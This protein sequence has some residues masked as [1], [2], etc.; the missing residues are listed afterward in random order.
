MPDDAPS[1]AV[2]RLRLRVTQ[3]AETALRQGHPWVFSDSVRET[4]RAGGPGEIA[5]VYD[6][7][8]RFLAAGLWDPESPIRFRALQV[9]KPVV[10]DDAWWHR[11]L[12]E[13]LQRRAGLFDENTDGYRCINGESDGWPGFVLDRFAGTFVIKIYTEAW[14]PHLPQVLS[15]LR[16]HLNPERLVLRTSRNI[17]GPAA[18]A[19]FADGTV[20]HGAAVEGPVVFREN[21]LRFEAEVVRGQKTGFFLD[22]RENR[23]RVGELAPGRSVLNAFSFSGGFSLCAARGGAVSVTDLDIS[24]HALAAGG[25]NFALN[26]DHPAVARCRREPVQVDAFEWV[27]NSQRR[28]GLI[29]L[30]PPSLARRESERAGAIQ[31]YERLVRDG[32]RL[33]EPGSVL[34]ACSC[35]AHVSAGEFEAA[36]R[37]AAASHGRA[38]TMFTRGH[39]PDHPATIPEAQYLKAVYLSFDR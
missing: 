30:D 36:V 27:R 37:R 4:N 39:A 11:R 31:A 34:V 3:A 14:L 38:F 7:K 25:R 8:D 29:I 9:G 19:G 20:L 2:P 22:Q 10:I 23:A 24:P 26:M 17:Q 13:A 32:V 15:T 12:Q 5:V 6:R 1:K 18:A 35:S 33:L 21:G 28:F 16:A